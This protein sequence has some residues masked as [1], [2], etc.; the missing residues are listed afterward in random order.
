VVSTKA[1]IGFIGVGY[2]GHGMA[3]NIVEK[4]HPLTVLAHHNRA[5]VDDLV[6]RGAREVGDPAEIAKNSEIVFLCVTGSSQVEAIIRAPRGLKDGAHSGLIIVDCSTA[7][8]NSTLALAEELHRL[9]VHLVDAPL[10]GT[11]TAA[12]EGKLSTMIGASPE[13]FAK[14]SPILATWAAKIDH[15]G[16]VGDGHKMKLINNFLSLGYGAI[17]A[18]ALA[19]A[20]KSGIAPA[21]FDRVIRGS[22]MDC[23][24]YQTFMKYVLDRDRD[25]HKFTLANAAK[26]LRY[27]AAMAD[28]A[29]I[30]NP[31]GNAVKNSYA[32][33]VVTGKG[34]EF[35]PMISDFVAAQNGTT[36]A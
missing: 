29:G 14:I 21:A 6:R 35:V 28:A 19:L 24:F 4:G 11:P 22:R 10:G 32:A 2:M 20:Q 9:G 33:A 7:D 30:A 3:K 36:L 27:L 15:I 1:K 16:A 31:I 12:W 26:D 5:P 8:P 17:Y 18:E 13:I 25:A 23:G 34:Q